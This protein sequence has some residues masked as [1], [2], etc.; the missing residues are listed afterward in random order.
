MFGFCPPF[1]P[2]FGNSRLHP[3]EWRL[4]PDASIAQSWQRRGRH[5]S[6]WPD[7]EATSLPCQHRAKQKKVGRE[8]SGGEW[9][10]EGT[11]AR[12]A[13]VPPSSLPPSPSSASSSF[14]SPLLFSYPAPFPSPFES[15]SQLIFVSQDYHPITGYLKE[16]PS[17][18][19]GS[20][21]RALQIHSS[22]RVRR[23]V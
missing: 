11:A 14:Y 7:A 18:V 4:Y 19:L 3:K 20:Q 16:G 23:V 12:A 1:T 17:S 6:S 15:T 9:R 10:R 13:D 21:R 8:D 22:Q 2:M 5:S